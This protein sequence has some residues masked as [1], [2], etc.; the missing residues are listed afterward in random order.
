MKDASFQVQRGADQSILFTVNTSETSLV[1]KNLADCT[2]RCVIGEAATTNLVFNK[3]LRI[4][5]APTG[6]AALD[7]SPAESRLIPE[8]RLAEVKIELR[9]GG[10]QIIV[11][12]GRVTGLGGIN[13]DN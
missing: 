11:G 5:D 10:L 2:L 9:E 12:R 1:A 13:L 4:I 3:A 7:L 6:Q 8:G